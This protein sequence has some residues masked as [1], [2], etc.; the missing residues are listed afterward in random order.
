[1][2]MN[3][4]TNKLDISF[5][6]ADGLSPVIGTIEIHYELEIDGVWQSANTLSIIVREEQRGH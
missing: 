4:V 5:A 6:A 2:V 3:V 1:M